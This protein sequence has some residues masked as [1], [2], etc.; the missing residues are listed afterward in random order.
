[1]LR[2]ISGV[3][4]PLDATSAP[5]SATP[6]SASSDCST[7][8][9]MAACSASGS[10]F[11]MMFSMAPVFS[12]STWMMA[13]AAAALPLGVAL[14]ALAAVVT[15]V[16]LEA[17]LILVGLLVLDESVAL[18]EHSITV[19]A[20]PALLNERVLLTQ[21]DT[22]VTLAGDNRVTVGAVELGHVL[23]VLLQDVHLHGS[24]LGETG[25]A[26][27]AFVWLL[28]RVC[29]HV[30]LQLVGVTAGVAAQ[31]ALERALPVWGSQCSSSSSSGW[32]CCSSWCWSSSCSTVSTSPFAP[33]FTTWKPSGRGRVWQIIGF[34]SL[35]MAVA[36]T[37]VPCSS[38]TVACV[39]GTAETGTWTS[40]SSPRP[41]SCCSFKL[42]TCRVMIWVSSTVVTVASW[43]VTTGASITSV[44][45]CSRAGSRES[46]TI[47]STLTPSTS[48]WGSRHASPAGCSS[49]TPSAACWSSILWVMI[50]LVSGD[51]NLWVMFTLVSGD[52]NLWV[53]ITL[54]S[55]D[56]NLW[57]MFT[58]VSGDSILWVMITLVSGDSNLWVIITVVSGD[59][60][61]WVMFTL[62]SGDSNLN[63]W[64]MFTLVSGDSN[65]WVMFT[66]V[67]GDSNLWVMFTLVSGDSNL[68]VMITLVSG[69]SN[70]W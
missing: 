18:V 59:S 64:V 8:T 45:I 23:C 53:M 24:T 22:Q 65:L 55:G 49:I 67:S 16:T 37:K 68:W 43:A 17:F 57:V 34:P 15:L 38:S 70:L 66:L 41:P 2:I 11:T 51:S 6:A 46:I 25:V 69:D 14:L 33:T 5:G 20:F 48:C 19:M 56:S 36:S 21:M 28:S 26:D 50:T 39:T 10:F 12:S 3:R 42:T 35:G 54:V 31:T 47:I 63:L 44:F 29:P 7:T 32:T 40:C 60:N 52:S 1:M 4:S 62:V 30:S 58:L 27:V 9:S 13:A 61:L